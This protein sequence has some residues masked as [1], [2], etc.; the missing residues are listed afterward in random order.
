M[1]DTDILLIGA[2][3]ILI[4]SI[5]KGLT[6][7]GFALTSLPL[8]TMFL[9]PKTAVPLITVCSVFLDGYTFSEARRL[10]QYKEISPLVVSGIVGMILGTYFLVSLD[11]DAIRLAIGI[12]TLL[13]TL[14]S[15]MGVK[16]EISNARTA[17]IPVGLISGV[18]GGLTSIS[19]PPVILFFNNQNV[20]KTV[21]RANLIAYFFSIYLATVP[22]YF[23]G[24]LL[25]LDLL[26][27]SIVMVPIMFLGANIG[28]RASK[29]VNEILFKKITLLLLLFTGI[30]TILSALG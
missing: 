3:I 4:A 25:T 8:L 23:F 2:F 30:M 5:V 28:I 9:T 20:E 22:S 7:F 6:G 14:A 17:S 13:F 1:L 29:K 21:F 10:V 19:G 11:S 26:G 15:L 27:S 12:V 16:R 18:L 24:N